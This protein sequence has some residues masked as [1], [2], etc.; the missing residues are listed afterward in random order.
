MPYW[1][2]RDLL[3]WLFLLL[4]AFPATVLAQDDRPMLRLSFDRQNDFTFS[5][6]LSTWNHVE[7]GRY[8]LDFQ[9]RHSNIYN[10]TRAEGKLVQLYIHSDI[11]QYFKLT[12]N[13]DAASW[14]ETDQY[15]KNQ[16]EKISLYGG[17]RYRP[18]SFLE[19]SPLLGYTWDTRTASLGT[20]GPALR[21]D[22]GITPALF[23]KAAHQFPDS[24]SMET[25][26]VA[27]YKDIRPRR[28]HN[29]ILQ[30]E[31]RKLFEEGVMIATGIRAGS[32]EL[33]DYQ[34]TSV[35]R[36]MS[37]SIMPYLELGY[38]FAPGLDWRSQNSLM[39][40]RRRF[41]FQNLA[42]ETPVENDLTFS[43]L[44]LSSI[45]KLQFIKGK[46]R[47][48]AAYEF[49]Y[50]SRSYALTNNTGLNS[51]DFERREALEKQKDFLKNYQ[52]V[53]FLVQNPIG[54]RHVLESRITNQYLQYDTQSEENFDDRDELSWIGSGKWMT[55]WDKRLFT[56]LNLHGNYRHYAF[57]LKE[58]S[59]DNYI[60][61]ALRLDFDFNWD[62]TKY[63]RL[64]GQQSIYVT[65]NVKDFV[66]YNKTDRSTRNLESNFKALWHPTRNFQAESNFRRKETH[67]SYLN[68]E[69]FSETTLDTN[70][71]LTTDVKFRQF[72]DGKAGISQFYVEGGYKHFDQTKRF[73]T[74]MVGLDNRLKAISLREISLQTG[75]LLAIGYRNKHQSTIDIGLWTQ[76]QIHK[77]RFDILDTDQIFGAALQESELNNI[78]FE[79][80][81]YITARVNYFWGSQK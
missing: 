17:V 76:F 31:W 50:S 2:G 34:A 43:G 61:R 60:Q 73:K 68:W 40:H 15:V 64:E 55:K 42:A 81:P 14:V 5:T 25:V 13:L 51:N 74:N 63:L 4:C 67:Q 57:L 53:E 16:N 70:R 12:K 29:L 38:A 6:D 45:Q 11:W 77:N 33:D 9:L 56:S 10:T 46:F 36:I 3:L 28:Q 35:K 39:A 78:N 20:S 54:K 18:W 44:E 8:T 23:L 41:L 69:E 58:K 75:P 30:Q 59:Q 32:H 26:L 27:R 21:V 1:C 49:M 66:D 19:I 24:L 62:V 52:K 7:R 37:D 65:Y 79:F 22:H 48:S 72:F 47:A 80:R 71:I